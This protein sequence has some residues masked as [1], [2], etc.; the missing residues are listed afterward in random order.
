ML[1]AL[2]ALAL[3]LRLRH[4]RGALRAPSP[5][6]ALV[7]RGLSPAALRASLSAPLSRGGGDAE[8]LR[9]MGR[10]ARSSPAEH[11]RAVRRAMDGRCTCSRLPDAPPARRRARS[12]GAAVRNCART[13]RLTRG[14]AETREQQSRAIQLIPSVAAACRAIAGMMGATRCRLERAAE[15]LLDSRSR[16]GE[17][18]PGGPRRPRIAAPGAAGR[19]ARPRRVAGRREHASPGIMVAATSCSPRAAAGRAVD[20]RWKT[21]V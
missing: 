6:C 12:G 3:A 11:S 13:D 18:H 1:S 20:R 10:C 5:G 2:V 19:A 16:H 9:D 14:S 15:A 7:D 21:F 17:R 8:A 4:G